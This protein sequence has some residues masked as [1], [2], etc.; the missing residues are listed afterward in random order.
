LPVQHRHCHGCLLSS[1]SWSP[2][3]VEAVLPI[4]LTVLAVHGCPVA[5]YT[6][7]LSVLTEVACDKVVFQEICLT[8]EVARYREVTPSWQSPHL[9]QSCVSCGNGCPR[10]LAPRCGRVIF[11]V[12][13]P[14]L[15]TS[16][17]PMGTT[18]AKTSSS[19]N[20]PFV[21]KLPTPVGHQITLL[22]NVAVLGDVSLLIKPRLSV[23]F[24]P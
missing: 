4:A 21:V 22:C 12:T 8:N 23:K 20:Q 6:L 14:N 1:S 5:G 9:W 19:A 10:R 11:L 17:S 2:S 3:F 18:L 24:L 15:A 7:C 16:H 13:V